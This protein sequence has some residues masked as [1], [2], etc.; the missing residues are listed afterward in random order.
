MDV[1]TDVMAAMRVGAP[2]SRRVAHATPF[3]WRFPSS[4]AAGF[5][6]VLQGSC[7]LH[8]PEGEPFLLNAGDLVFLSRGCTHALADQLSTPLIDAALPLADARARNSS[9]P[10]S[11]L[12][13]HATASTV[14]LCGAYL[15]D[16]ARLHPL[17]LELPDVFRIVSRVGSH[18][19][20]RSAIELLG[21][22]LEHDWTGSTAAIAAIVELLLIYILRNWIAGQRIE[23]TRTGWTA[24]LNDPRTMAVLQH[25]HECPERRWTLEAMA[26]IAGMSRS[27]FA[28]RFAELLGQPPVT[29][30]TWWRMTIAA[31]WLRET[32]APIADICGRVGYSSEFAFAHAFKKEF[33]LA[34]G[35]YRRRGKL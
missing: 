15:F 17:L 31:R 26:E 12:A 29:Y 2:H 3:G 9:A 4:A 33:G 10:N 27:S 13:S 20:L 22:E 11:G 14:L 21:A 24:A 5:H 6:I 34:P 18:P 35:S 8:P 7:W 16:R 32:D 1:L 23:G 25:V 30:V 28:R 19:E